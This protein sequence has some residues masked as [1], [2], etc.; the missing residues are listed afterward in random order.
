MTEEK[1]RHWREVAEAASNETNSEKLHTLAR[2]LVAALDGRD[3]RLGGN[4]P[5]SPRSEQVGRRLLFVDDEEGIRLTLPSILRGHSF[6]VHVASSVSEALTQ[7]E[8]Q[9]YDVLLCDLNIS[10]EGDGFTVVRAIREA[11]PRC[12][13][14]LLTGYPGIE[15]AAQAIHIEI[16]DYFVKP[17]D[18]ELLVGTIERQLRARAAGAPGK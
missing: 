9:K 1:R 16:D 2:E 11:N 15:S 18:I 5:T 8:K 14:I 12:V 10:I 6:D 13:V 17:A 4:L 3:N 7:I